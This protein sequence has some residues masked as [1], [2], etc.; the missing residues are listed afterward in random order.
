MNHSYMNQFITDRKD[1]ESNDKVIMIVRINGLLT[2]VI[3][4]RSW[5]NPSIAREQ[6][7]ADIPN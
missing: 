7:S 5:T 2:S 6:N 1:C 3:Y 4:T